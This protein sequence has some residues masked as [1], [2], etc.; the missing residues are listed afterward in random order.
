MVSAQLRGVKGQLSSQLTRVGELRDS[1]YPTDPDAGEIV[2]QAF[3]AIEE[4]EAAV[5]D[6]ADRISHRD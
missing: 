6:A 2:H 5:Q 1:L 3:L 4:A